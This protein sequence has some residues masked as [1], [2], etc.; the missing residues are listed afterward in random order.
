MSFDPNRIGP[1]GGGGRVGPPTPATAKPPAAPLP[2]LTPSKDPIP[3]SAQHEVKQGKIYV[4]NTV[5]LDADPAQV[6]A[7]VR[8]KDW[9]SYWSTGRFS[10]VPKGVELPPAVAGE[11]RFGMTPIHFGP[12]APPSFAVQTFEPVAEP[13]PGGGYKVVVPYR[14]TGGFSGDA[15]LEIAVTPD[16][17]TALTSVWDGVSPPTGIWPVPQILAA[18]HVSTEVKAFKNLGAMLAR[19]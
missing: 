17:K 5:V 13:L 2:A 7:A 18:A 1:A 16:G 4:R 8:G 6:L 12:L 14:L 19:P 15:R 11:V 3:E 10:G 9:S